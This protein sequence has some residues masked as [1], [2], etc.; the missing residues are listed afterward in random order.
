M[1][2]FRWHVWLLRPVL[3]AFK[4]CTRLL[5]IEGSTPAPSG[6]SKDAMQGSFWVQI[7]HINANT[8]VHLP[9]GTC[10]S[11]NGVRSILAASFC[12]LVAGRLAMIFFTLWDAAR[13]CYSMGKLALALPLH[14]HPAQ[15]SVV[16]RP[17]P[18]CLLTHDWTTSVLHQVSTETCCAQSV[19][20]KQECLTWGK[21]CSCEGS[22]FDET[23]CWSLRAG[24]HWKLSQL[25]EANCPLL[26]A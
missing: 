17:V 13:R 3:H 19:S 15:P 14:A 10:E 18:M 6:K 16:H 23:C 9:L 8:Y 4:S 22:A 20:T 12:K 5:N 21:V 1:N 26:K 25:A 2:S 24:F 7:V 11:E